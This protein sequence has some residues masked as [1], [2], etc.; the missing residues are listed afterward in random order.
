MLELVNHHSQAELGRTVTT[1]SAAPPA[2][3]L[4]RRTPFSLG[5]CFKIVFVAN[6]RVVFV[7][8]E[9]FAGF[10]SLVIGTELGQTRL[11]AYFLK[12]LR[13]SRKYLL[14]SLTANNYDSAGI[15]IDA[16]QQEYR[17]EPLSEII[18]AK[19]GIESVLRPGLFIE[20]LESSIED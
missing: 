19:R 7:I 17:Q 13:E 3:V 12:H 10:I 2:Y 5:N 11:S 1:E 16:L 14:M 20:I 15:P 9:S 8:D 6:Y 18:D 4:Y